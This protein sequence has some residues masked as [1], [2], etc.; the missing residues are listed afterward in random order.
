MKAD[1]VKDP[2]SGKRKRRSAYP[3]GRKELIGYEKPDVGKK[4]HKRDNRSGQIGRTPL[5][6]KFR[7]RRY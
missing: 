1:R 7:F 2:R 4:K 6:G 5:K 3:S